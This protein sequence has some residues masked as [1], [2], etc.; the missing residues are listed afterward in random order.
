MQARIHR[1]KGKFMFKYK[2]SART[3]LF[4][5]KVNPES[6]TEILSINDSLRMESYRSRAASSRMNSRVSGLSSFRSAYCRSK[7]RLCSKSLRQKFRRFS[8]KCRISTAAARF[9][10]KT[11]S[12]SAS[13]SC[14]FE[15]SSP[16]EI[17]AHFLLSQI[18]CESRS[19]KEFC[20][21]IR[22]SK[23]T[24]KGFAGKA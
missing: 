9:T 15:K 5:V 3:C 24:A 20:G 4:S 18:R 10:R 19:S 1:T 2:L 13:P 8:S 11:S 22:P 17:P 23:S 7:E 16:G 6:S 14:I 21:R 12:E